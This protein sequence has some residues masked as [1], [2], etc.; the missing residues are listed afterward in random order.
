TATTGA[1]SAFPLEDLLS[2]GTALADAE[3]GMLN[4][5]RSALDGRGVECVAVGVKRL[6]L[7]PRTSRSVLERMKATR[8]V[9]ARSEEAKG[10]A[11]ASRIRAEASTKADRI[12]AYT[13]RRAEE[14]RAEGEARAAKYLEQ[15]QEEPELA[16]FLVWLDALQRSLSKNTT[17]ILPWNAAPWHLMQPGTAAQ[18][19]AGD[20]PQ[21]VAVGP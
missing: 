14:I 4:N 19:A 9:L 17:L 13:G 10:K 11:E 8:D 16:T 12:R 7:P 6:M 3:S 20:I 21:P 18:T 5:V 1:I 15:M 2:N